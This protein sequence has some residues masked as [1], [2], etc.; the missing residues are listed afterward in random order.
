MRGRGFSLIEVLFS[1]G[2]STLVLAALF[3]LLRGGTRQF[4]LSSAQVFLGQST[5]E[6]VEDALSFASSAV[7]PASYS[8]Q[9]VYSPTPGCSESDA[10]Y[11]NI[12][13]LDFASC[14]DLLDPR[15][16]S[17]PEL[18]AGYLNRR[19]GG[20][21]RYRIRFDLIKQQ[22]VLER[23]QPN[24]AANNPQ[25]DPTVPAKVLCHSL[26][27]VTFGALGNTIHM[28]V[29]TATMKKN[30]EVQGGLQITDS[31]KSLDPTAPVQ[32]QSRRLQLFTVVTIPSRTTR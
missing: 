20:R 27:R 32:Q 11:P 4:E 16:S 28:N 15:F 13:N 19:T 9:A 7:A 2:L 31:R 25:L 6:A 3:L 22:L 17:Q 21:F 8:T 24:T 14:C 23:L 26:D 5:R 18:T 12:Y 29:A 30:G 10:V 1:L